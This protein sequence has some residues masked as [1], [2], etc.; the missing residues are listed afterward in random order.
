MN[1]EQLL[2]R[3]SKDSFIRVFDDVGYITNQLTQRDCAYDDVG[4]V[5]LQQISRTPKKV[6]QI[7][8][9]LKALFSDVPEE[10]LEADLLEFI[11]DLETD[12][13]VVTGRSRTE[14]DHKEPRFTYSTADPKTIA[15]D[16]SPQ[17]EASTLTDT[18]AFLRERFRKSPRILGMQIEATSHC[19]E[20]C[21]HCYLPPERTRRHIETAMLLDV[22]AQAREMET[23][24]M[25]FSGGEF[26]MHPDFA[27]I[28]QY[29]RRNDFM[30]SVLS[31]GTLITDEL[32]ALLKEVNINLIQ[33]SLYS[34]D[35]D[36]HDTVTQVEGSFQKT[37]KNLE[38]L[39]A[40]DVPTQISC[41]IMKTNRHSY[42]GVLQW[43]YQHKIKVQA[44]LIIMA[45]FDFSTSNLA[46]RATPQETEQVIRDM[47]AQDIGY[48]ALLNLEPES[49]VAGYAERPVCGAGVDS[50]CVDAGGNFYP[51]A[52]WQGYVVGNAYKQRLR[53]VWENSEQLRFLRRTTNADLPRC[54]KC[55]AKDYCAICLAKNF[56]ESHGD[57][58]WVNPHYCEVAFLNKRIV[59]EYKHGSSDA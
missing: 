39:I 17:N 32:I 19:N 59:E 58:F 55:E 49:D 44:D 21:I 34:M 23:I 47:L 56:N 6:S 22:M 9:E 48:Q 13:F 45:R 24:G 41:P 35:A 52:G 40:A 5:F 1:S 14:L 4:T 31:N 27:E 51:C 38:K 42:L 15:I 30:M 57:M 11:T 29:G 53:D 8:R 20:R 36:V 37:I 12:A 10:M 7:V 50:M 18:E 16:F 26:L 3:Q 28:L 43:A 33:V 2:V 54:L 46:H 25:I